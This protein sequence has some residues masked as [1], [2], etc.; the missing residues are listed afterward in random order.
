MDTKSHHRKK[1]PQLHFNSV[2]PCRGMYVGFRKHLMMI[3]KKNA[4]IAMVKKTS[5]TMSPS[6]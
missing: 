6:G 5:M 4:A 1:D 3:S 2:Q